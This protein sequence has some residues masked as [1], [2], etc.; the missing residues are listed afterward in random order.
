MS[1]KKLRALI[2]TAI[3]AAASIVLGKFAAI[4]IGDTIRISFENFPIMLAS[5]LF[6]PI[7]G[8]ACGV[9]ADLLGCVL[10]GYAIIPLITVAAGLMGIIPGLLSRYV[11]KKTS[12]PYIIAFGF[13]SHVICSM[14]VKTVALHITYMTPY[15]ALF[16]TRVPV[17]VATGLLEAYLCSVLVQRKFV[18]KEIII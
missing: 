3:F 13:A 11:F 10:R 18:K 7:W 6:G 4:S 16:S 17:Y 14:I 8:A 5:F 12:T 1:N 15:A 2:I 9:V